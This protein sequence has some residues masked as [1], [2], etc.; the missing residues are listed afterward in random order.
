MQREGGG[1]SRTDK[2]L[3]VWERTMTILKPRGTTFTLDF[4]ARLQDACED[5]E[6]ARDENEEWCY[7]E[8]FEYAFD[9][10]MR[11]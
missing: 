9:K 11:E 3:I 2:Y 5:F 7:A 8:M 4:L 10:A 6:A 1:Y